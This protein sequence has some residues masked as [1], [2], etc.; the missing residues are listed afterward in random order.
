MPTKSVRVSKDVSDRLD[1]LC[2]TQ[3]LNKRAFVDNALRVAINEHPCNKVAHGFTAAT[4]IHNA[5]SD[6]TIEEG[7][8]N[9]SHETSDDINDIVSDLPDSDVPDLPDPDEPEDEQSDDDKLAEMGFD[10]DEY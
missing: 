4:D 1:E 2:M 9:V 5:T 8:Q 7:T 10:V 6:I 3:M